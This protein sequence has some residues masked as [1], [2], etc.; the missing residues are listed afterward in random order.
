MFQQREKYSMRK[1]TT[2]GIQILGIMLMFVSC[3]NKL[4]DVDYVNISQDLMISL[5]Q[6][7]TNEGGQPTIILESNQV[8]E[9][10]NV[11]INFSKIETNENIQIDISDYA[12]PQPDECILP[13]KSAKIALELKKILGKRR[14]QFLLRNTISNTGEIEISE[15]EMILRIFDQNGIDIGTNN[16][17]FIPRSTIFGK[18]S[19]DSL[20]N[21][22]EKSEITDFINS[23]NVNNF[24]PKP[25]NYGHFFVSFDHV[26]EFFE[27]NIN[28]ENVINFFIQVDHVDAR[29]E[30]LSQFLDTYQNISYELTTWNGL[31]YKK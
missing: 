28:S 11:G 3:S 21:P 19:L 10:S 4:D 26:I 5:G 14:L 13:G 25:G 31:K 27:F 17:N 7:L 8:F 12:I 1:V 2:K 22:N 6:N 20:S 23:Q 29:V 16:L 18:I 30:E 24:K 9:C 15:D